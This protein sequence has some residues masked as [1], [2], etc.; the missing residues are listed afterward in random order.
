[1]MVLI[2]SVL[3]ALVGSVA[4]GAAIYEYTGNPFSFASGPFSTSDSVTAVVEFS[5]VPAPLGSFDETD[6]ADYSFSAGPFTLTPSTPGATVAGTFTFDATGAVETW[7]ITVTGFAA[8]TGGG[9][10]ELINTDWNGVDGDDFA[11]V[12][13]GTAGIAFNEQVPGTWTL[14]PEPG[15]A[16]LVLGC[17]SVVMWVRRRVVS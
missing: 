11:D 2:G 14:V 16:G 3:A 10:D 6:I 4:R 15:G 12:D 13:D 5:S 1:M 9:L 17:L 7:L 8:G